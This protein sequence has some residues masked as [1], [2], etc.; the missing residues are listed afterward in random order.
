MS[1]KQKSLEALELALQTEDDGYRMYK[2]AMEGELNE[3]SRGLFSQLAK[4]ELLHKDLI[5]RF[6]AQ[7]NEAG[8]WAAVS[9]EDKKAGEMKGKYKTIFSEALQKMGKSGKEFSES[10]KEAYQKAIEF[11]KNGMEMYDRLYNETEDP[12]AKYFYGF[13]REMEREHM[14]VLENALQFVNNPDGWLIQN[15]GW[16]ME[17]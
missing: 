7:L 16:T 3:L 9:E 13:L 12:Q 2:T 1:D 8:T 11:E 10:E 14:E 15:E 5:K 6:Y 4:D 17:D